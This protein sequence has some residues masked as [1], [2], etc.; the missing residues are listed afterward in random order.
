MAL[1]GRNYHDIDALL[2]EIWGLDVAILPRHPAPS[3][4]RLMLSAREHR[5]LCHLLELADRFDSADGGPASKLLKRVQTARTVAWD[6][7]ILPEE[8]EELE[9]DP[10]VG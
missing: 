10:C 7:P 1:A 5:L 6:D 2:R 4:R 8:L 9:E 3:W